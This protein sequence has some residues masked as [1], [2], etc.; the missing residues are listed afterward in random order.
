ML[1]QPN[2]SGK[3]LAALSG[4]IY[5][6]EDEEKILWLSTDRFPMHRRCLQVSLLPPPQFVRP[7]QRFF[8]QNSTLCMGDFFSIDL[9]SLKDW[10]PH[11][12]FLD[13]AK[14][15]AGVRHRCDQFFGFIQCLGSVEGLAQFIP[16]ISQ[17]AEGKEISLTLRDFP[18]RRFL[19]PILEIGKASLGRDM[20]EI[21]KKGKGLVG[22]GPGLTPSGDDF[23]G[24][25]LF[26]ACLLRETYPEV[27]VWDHDKISDFTARARSQTNPISHSF[28]NDFALGHGPANLHEVMNF[29]IQGGNF[30]KAVSAVAQFLQFGHSSGGDVLAGLMTGMLMVF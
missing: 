30:E 10:N 14:S 9:A 21:L 7:G 6:R 20:A 24:G 8:V 19:L 5:M 11:P 4:T 28:L 13:E 18:A 1:A 16:L 22:L 25:L 12:I 27:F 23:L 3:V 29:L 26:S 15:L 17:M 2:F